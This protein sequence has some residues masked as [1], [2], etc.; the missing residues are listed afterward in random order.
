M[1][2]DRVWVFD[3]TI[4]AA[5]GGVLLKNGAAR[6][7]AAHQWCGWSPGE[8]FAHGDREASEKTA[9]L[10]PTTEIKKPWYLVQRRDK[11]KETS[12]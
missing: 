11:P 6:F 9:T 12:S 1:Q 8:P 2:Q 3:G 5:E 4:A 7:V 10:A